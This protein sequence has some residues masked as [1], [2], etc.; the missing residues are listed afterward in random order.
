K[1]PSASRDGASAL[2]DHDQIWNSVTIYIA[3]RE[4]VVPIATRRV[5]DG[6]LKTTIAIP[7][8]HAHH[9]RARVTS[10]A[11]DV[12]YDQIQNSVAPQVRDCDRLRQTASA[13]VGH[14]RFELA[15]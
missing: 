6:R 5:T 12:G 8:Q 9:V 13:V 1:A 2:F 10:Y 3:N 11:N 7:Q 4:R 15:V 14:R